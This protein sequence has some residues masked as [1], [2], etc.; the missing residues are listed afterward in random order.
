M[1]RHPSGSAEEL[2]QRFADHLVDSEAGLHL[3]HASL[4]IFERAKHMALY[5]DEDGLLGL[6]SS[7]LDDEDIDRQ[8][9]AYSAGLLCLSSPSAMRLGRV[10]YCVNLSG[11]DHLL[12]LKSTLDGRN[13]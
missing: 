11:Q 6:S 9:D 4:G 2:F 12:G 3:L 5:R 8:L 10:L 1:S 13:R 7:D